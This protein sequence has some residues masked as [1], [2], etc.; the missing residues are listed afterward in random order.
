MLLSIWILFF[1]T[2]TAAI[3]PDNIDEG[4]TDGPQSTFN[5]LRKRNLQLDDF[6]ERYA[7]K[8]VSRK[9]LHSDDEEDLGS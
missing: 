2:V 3:L 7:G 5:S 4:I 6:D 9:R 8:A 1:F